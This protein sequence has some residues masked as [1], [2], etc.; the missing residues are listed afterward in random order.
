MAWLG[1]GVMTERPR[2]S[3]II[4]TFGDPL[5]KTPENPARCLQIG[6]G[7]CFVLPDSRST[8]SAQNCAGLMAKS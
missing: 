7:K 2:I 8:L 1:S 5:A 3:D 6:E 4:L